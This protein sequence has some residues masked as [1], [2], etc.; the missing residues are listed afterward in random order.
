MSRETQTNSTIYCGRDVW[1]ILASLGLLLSVSWFFDP[2][3]ASGHS[4]SRTAFPVAK[5]V[6]ASMIEERTYA[7]PAAPQPGSTGPPSLL[8]GVDTEL[9][10]MGSCRRDGAA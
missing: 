7:E 4:A 2:L 6:F 1:V 9:L 8:F 3:H 5:H 10:L